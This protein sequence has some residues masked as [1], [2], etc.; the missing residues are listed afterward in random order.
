MMVS[1][2]VPFYSNTPDNTHCYQAALRMV[3]KYFFP[4]KDFSW[5]KLDEMT[6]KKKGKWTWPS[7]GLI[8]LK[9][10]GFDVVYMENFDYERF[11]KEGEKYLIV[12]YGKKVGE[13]QIKYRD[14]AQ[15]MRIAGDLLEIFGDTNKIPSLDDI[16]KFLRE[17]YLVGCNVN[18]RILEERRGYV[19]H[20]VVVFGFGK[21]SLYLHDPGLPPRKNREV[22]VK[23]FMKA[24]YYPDERSA[25]L[26]A[27]KLE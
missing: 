6:A 20:F 15:E 7:Q 14:V 3:L 2:G 24:W 21:D 1:T 25:N 13:A 26:Q 9:K 11:S 8:N 16:R 4:D 27:F 5:G 18:S 10:M 19:G 22:S 17:G 23:R 12:H